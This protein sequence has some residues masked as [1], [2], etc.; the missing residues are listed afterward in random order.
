MCSKHHILDPKTRFC[1]DYISLASLWT[2]WK[3]SN[4]FSEWLIAF[5]G[6][7]TLKLSSFWGVVLLAV[8][9]PPVLNFFGQ[10]LARLE[11]ILATCSLAKSMKKTIHAVR[12]KQIG[13]WYFLTLL[14]F[15]STVIGRIVDWLVRILNSYYLQE[16]REKPS[17]FSIRSSIGSNHSACRL[18]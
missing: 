18:G 15:L 2:V 17:L 10:S 1:T 3:G 11:A 12:L 4:D 8:Q 9:H 13:N 6:I 7:A 14:W 5:R 16:P